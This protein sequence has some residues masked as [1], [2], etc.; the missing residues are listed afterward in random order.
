VGDPRLRSAGRNYSDDLKRFMGNHSRIMK[1][2]RTV[3]RLDKRSINSINW[4]IRL[5]DRDSPISSTRPG[6]KRR[7]LAD[8]SKGDE[9]RIGDVKTG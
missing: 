9:Q 1:E 5:G 7:E 3:P 6:K 8:V 4:N 2:G